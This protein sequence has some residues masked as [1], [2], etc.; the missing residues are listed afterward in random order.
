MFNQSLPPEVLG[1]IKVIFF[2]ECDELL[3]SLDSGLEALKQ[4]NADPDTINMVFRAV[5]SIKGGAA[6][7]EFVRLTQFSHSFEAVLSDLRAGRIAASAVLFEDLLHASD[8]LAELVEEAHG[9]KVWDPGK[10]EAALKALAGYIRKEDE[11]TSAGADGEAGPIPA[12]E[13]HWNEIGDLRS[14]RIVFRPAASLYRRANDPLLLFRDLS[15]LGELQLELNLHDL[16]N[17]ADLEPDRAYLGWTGILRTLQSEQAIWDVF[18]FA[19][20]D[21]HLEIVPCAVEAAKVPPERLP[22]VAN[23]AVSSNSSDPQSNRVIRVDLDRVDKLFNLVEELLVQQTTFNHV[24]GKQLAPEV[25]PVY[26]EF[27]RLSKEIQEG[28]LAIRSQ[29]LKPVFQRMAR[30]VR[31][32]E[33]ATGKS[34]TFAATGGEAEVDRSVL[35]RLAEPLTHLI[36]NAVDHGLESSDE[37]AQLGKSPSGTIA[38]RAYQRFGRIVLEVSDDGEGIDRERVLSTAISRGLIDPNEH[39]SGPDIDALIFR[40]GFSTAENVSEIS[41]RG[42]GMDVVNKC[43]RAL[44]GRISMSS[45]KGVGTTFLLSL[46]LTLALLEGIV[47]GSGSGRFIVPIASLLETLQLRSEE[48]KFIGDVRVIRYRDQ[49]I[50]LV[51]LA[52]ILGYPQISGAH[53]SIGIVVED[54]LGARIAIAV[55]EVFEQQQ[56]VVKEIQ[57]AYQAN[58]GVSAATILG[59][60][61]VALILDVNGIVERQKQNT[62]RAQCY[63]EE[64]DERVSRWAIR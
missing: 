53:G 8:V 19:G 61:Q 2:Q 47:V 16:P 3:A 10:T 54:D 55:D 42:V 46:P 15:R 57:G 43:V 1:P 51:E 44:G 32:L 6:N 21:C 39:L 63:D 50:P 59:D 49:Y 20:G 25:Q 22:Q 34:V 9:G 64:S 24:A 58:H 28:L 29:P 18:E 38:L 33:Q 26:A 37:R 14:W 56:I 4:G 60:G 12:P 30:L 35:E 5:H 40:P 13:K 52:A 7:F 62:E 17:L 36:R 23:E 45:Q 41:G 27:R 31:Q 48:V 11:F